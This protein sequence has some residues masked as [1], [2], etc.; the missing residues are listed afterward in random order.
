M[1]MAEGEKIQQYG[2]R[3]KEI[4]REI[5]SVGGTVEDTIV[6]SKVLRTLLPVYAI[7]V[8]A[9][10]KLKFIDK[11]KVTLDSIIGKLT[12]FELNSFDGSVQ[13]SEFAFRASV[14]TPLVRKRREVSYNHESRSSREVDD[15]DSLIELE[16]L[17]AKQ[18][19]RGIGKYRGKLPLKCFAC[20]RIGHIVANCPNGDN[21]EKREKYR[22]YKGKGKRH[23][24]IVVDGGITNE[25]SEEDANEDIAIVAIKEEIS[26]LR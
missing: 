18:L 14:S 21:E 24:L 8:A 26:T 6:V 17:L 1:W 16:A 11:K 3:I 19:P 7:R 10:H 22:K 15:E 20:N 13:R 2:Q 9:I 25:E 12:A 4:V 5:K 23:C